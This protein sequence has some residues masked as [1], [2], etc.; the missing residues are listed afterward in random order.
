M[1]S[2]GCVINDIADRN[3]DKHVFRTKTRPLTSGEVSLQQAF[4]VLFGLLT[5]ALIVLL[6]LPKACFYYALIALGL[7][8]IYPF[9]KRWINAPQAVLGLAF[10]MGIPMAY[11]AS[12]HPLNITTFLL[13][14]LNL[15]WVIAYDT[16]YA[17]VD[18]ADD[19]KIGVKSTAI[20][21]GKW[22][23]HIIT[24]L[25]ILIQIIWMIIG[26]VN[27]CSLIF[28][29]SWTIAIFVFIYQQMMIKKNEPEA[30]FRA[31]LSNG[32]YGLIL[33]VGLV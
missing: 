22:T 12:N 21:F 24:A 9:C 25:Q 28:Y 18:K 11:V 31:F 5:L 14:I 16:Q 6:L 26:I 3:I 29:V 15:A 8:T 1:R 30:Y 23:Q 4:L 27:Q 17:M 7:T 2:A 10:S 33:W 19:L 32:L 20:L 13:I